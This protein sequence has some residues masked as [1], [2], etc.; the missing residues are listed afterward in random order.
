MALI[1]KEPVYAQ[2][3]KVNHRILSFRIVELL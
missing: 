2:L 1:Y 3:L